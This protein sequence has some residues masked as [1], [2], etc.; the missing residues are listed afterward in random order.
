MASLDVGG[1]IQEA[2]LFVSG[3]AGQASY[4]IATEQAVVLFAITSGIAGGIAQTLAGR[5][6]S[7]VDGS[8]VEAYQM[9]PAVALSF[10]ATFIAGAYLVPDEAAQP[11][12]G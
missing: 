9:A 2:G 5:R 6:L 8:E 3:L 7:R 12:V 10:A 1:T 11:L 4:P